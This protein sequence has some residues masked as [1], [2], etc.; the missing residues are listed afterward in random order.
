[1]WQII[2]A[3]IGLLIMTIGAYVFGMIIFEKNEENNRVDLWKAILLIFLFSIPQT[4]VKINL[5]NTVKTFIIFGLDVFFYKCC[6]KISYKKSI[7]A[8][9]IYMIL[10][11][12]PDLME[13]FFVTKI[14]HLNMEYCYNTF[15]G[16][17]LS[18]AVVCILFLLIAMILRKPL[19][20]L[21][22][23]KLENDKKIIIYLFLIFICIG[24]FFYTIIKE[25]RFSNNILI[26]LFSI[27]VLVIVLFS[28]MKQTIINNKIRKEYDQL[29]E[30]MT[31]YEEEIEKQRTLRHETKNEFLA[32]RAKICDKEK[33]EAIVKYIDS[34]LG[35]SYLIKQEKYAKFGYLPPNGIKGLCYFKTQKAESQGINVSINIS[36]KIKGSTIFELDTKMQREFA[37]ILGVFLDNAIEASTE[38]KEK[39]LGIEA[40]SNIDNEFRMIISNTYNNQINEE[41]MGKEAFTTKGKGHGHGLLLVNEMVKNNILFETK[42]EIKNGIYSQTI[43]VK[44][45]EKKV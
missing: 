41:K 34:I 40:Y 22:S 12:I 2:N 4:I 26:Y 32:I 39:E 30:F 35:D 3:Y 25:F 29:L 33:E 14:L 36:K 16:S 5:V 24:L 18:N 21:I 10:L 1:M 31:T 23:T 43:I 17:V 11:I 27:A 8:T 45:N 38:S 19:R 20:K 15:A 44:R 7:F 13:L 42:R 6:F 28:L 37:K 9:F